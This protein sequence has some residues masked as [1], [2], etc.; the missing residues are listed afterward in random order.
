M[1]LFGVRFF[2]SLYWLSRSARLWTFFPCLQLWSRWY[3]RLAEWLSEMVCLSSW[4]SPCVVMSASSCCLPFLSWK[5]ISGSTGQSD[6]VEPELLQQVWWLFRANSWHL[7]W[8]ACELLFLK[9]KIQAFFFFK[10]SL[11]YS[12][13]AK[14]GVTQNSSGVRNLGLS[15]KCS[16]V[17][18]GGWDRPDH[19]L[20]D[21]HQL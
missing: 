19:H 10:Q 9:L 13:V 7:F 18:K 6:S 5:S 15:W 11:F 16:L 3:K 2:F 21:P 17:G 8:I 20:Q 4:S 14:C 12:W 1:Y